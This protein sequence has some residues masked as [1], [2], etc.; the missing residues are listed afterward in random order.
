MSHYIRTRC[1]ACEKF[2]GVGVGLTEISDYTLCD[3][4]T[5]REV[6]RHND[7]KQ[8]DQVAALGAALDAIFPPS[9]KVTTHE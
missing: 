5:T 9:E 6:E 3:A 8:R 4:C 2:V 7:N 1:H